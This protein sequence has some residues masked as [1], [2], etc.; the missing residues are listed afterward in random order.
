VLRQLPL[1]SS[2]Q[3]IEAFIRANFVHVTYRVT[4]VDDSRAFVQLRTPHVLIRAL[5]MTGFPGVDRV[6]IYL[7]VTAEER[8]K[9][10]IV[11]SDEAYV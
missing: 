5:D 11:H 7:V 10:V 6:E 9:D 8:L 4:T 1:G 2:R 3:Q